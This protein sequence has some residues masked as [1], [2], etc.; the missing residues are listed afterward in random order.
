MNRQ[1]WLGPLLFDYAD[2]AT[3]EKWKLIARVMMLNAIAV[4]VLSIIS[5]LVLDEKL[6]LISAY[7][8]FF[9][10]LSRFFEFFE[11]SAL[12]P[13]VME[14]LFYRTAV[15]FFT[16]NTIKFYS[17]NKDLTSLFLWLAIIIPSAYWAIV[18]HPI[19]PPVFFAGI[20]WGWLVA[21]TKSW[22]PAV[23]SHVLS[24]TFIFFIAK[25]LNLIAPQFLKNL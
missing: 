17:R 24:N 4:P 25:V 1:K 6:N 2:V 3:K 16:V 23:I 12:Q 15:W 22:W 7:P 14:E 20:T 11:S 9:Y 13:A 8:Q 21:K 5:Y 19:A 10:P 18:S